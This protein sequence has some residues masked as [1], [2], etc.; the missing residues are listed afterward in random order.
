MLLGTP[1]SGSD[2]DSDSDYCTD[3]DDTPEPRTVETRASS[4]ADLSFTEWILNGVDEE[5]LEQAGVPTSACKASVDKGDES[6]ADW[7][8]QGL[9]EDVLE[10]T[11]VERTKE[12]DTNKLAEQELAWL[13]QD[14]IDDLDIEKYLDG[15][16]GFE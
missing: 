13:Q 6:F 4:E 7:A 15:H 10:E 1:P 11:P 14:D 16:L 9:P 12:E 2:S 8:M 3:S 5:F